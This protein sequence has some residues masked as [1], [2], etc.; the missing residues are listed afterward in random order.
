M[1]AMGHY[2]SSEI[3]KSKLTPKLSYRLASPYEGKF[4]FKSK[5]DMQQPFYPLKFVEVNLAFTLD[6]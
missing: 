1:P 3:K 5:E 4:G 6:S 2:D